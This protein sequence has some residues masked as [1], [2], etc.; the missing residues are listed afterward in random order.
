LQDGFFG[1]VYSRA[2]AK[3]MR[4]LFAPHE[5]L[6]QGLPNYDNELVG[7]AKTVR[8]FD[9]AVT[10]VTFGF[11]SVD[12]Y[13]DAS[14]SRLKIGDVRVPLLVVQAKDDPIAVHSAVPR[15]VIKGKTTA[16]PVV[17][18]ET[19]S[20]GHLGWTA[21]AEA[22]FGSPWPDVGAMQFFEACR[23]GVG[24]MS[25]GDVDDAAPVEAGVS[26]EVGAA[27]VAVEAPA[28]R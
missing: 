14:S 26:A 17:L 7:N 8:D 16:G 9:E 11:P 5:H 22:P 18:V 15:D 27:E 28:A 20:G 19:E 12:A 3:N 21:G 13:Y 2:M 25:S 10:R 24:R 6:F 1:T 4:A 23:R